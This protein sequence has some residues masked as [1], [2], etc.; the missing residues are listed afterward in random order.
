MSKASVRIQILND[1]DHNPEFVNPDPYEFVA[2][3]GAEATVGVVQ[4]SGIDLDSYYVIRAS[5]IYV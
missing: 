2:E 3:W 4:V 1:N 5:V